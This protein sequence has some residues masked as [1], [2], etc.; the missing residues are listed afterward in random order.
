MP[1]RGQLYNSSI[2]TN[3]NDY[4]RVF[5]DVNIRMNILEQNGRKEG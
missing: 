4:V 5:L 1:I 3:V 2:Y